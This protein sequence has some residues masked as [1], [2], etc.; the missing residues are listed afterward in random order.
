MNDNASSTAG[1]GLSSVA[2]HFVRIVD[3]VRERGDIGLRKEADRAGIRGVW[4]LLAM[5][6]AMINIHQ[7]MMGQL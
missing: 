1:G 7:A 4:L 3:R 2:S 6:M 5:A